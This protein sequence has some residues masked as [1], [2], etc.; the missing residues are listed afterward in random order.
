MPIDRVTADHPD[1]G[2]RRGRSKRDE[3]YREHNELTSAS[4][5]RW[6]PPRSAA[7]WPLEG[8]DRSARGGRT[9]STALLPPVDGTPR[10]CC[11]RS[12]GAAAELAF[13]FD[14]REVAGEV[15]RRL[16]ALRRP[17]DMRRRRHHRDRRQRAHGAGARRGDA[18]PARRRRTAPPPRDR[19]Q[20]PRRAAT[21][22]RASPDS[23]WLRVLVRR[24]RPG[25]RDEA[26][27]SATSVAAAAGATRHGAAAPSRPGVR[28]RARRTAARARSPNGS[29]RSPELVAQGLTNRQIAAPLEDQRAHRRH[30]RAAHPHQ[31]GFHQ[32]HPDRRLGYVPAIRSSADVRTQAPAA[33]SRH[34]HALGPP[35][36][37]RHLRHPA[38]RRGDR[39]RTRP[40]HPGR[41]RR[42]GPG[43][44]RRRRHHPARAG[45]RARPPRVRR[46]RRPGRRARRPRRR[47]GVRR[48]D[49]RRAVR[50][51]RRA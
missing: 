8:D 10:S 21:E 11:C 32:P 28:R 29:A 2:L 34:D 30:S 17:A 48:D 25:D 23:A 51:P 37:R 50:R 42:T 9:G 39:P 36:L 27:G 46:L 15:V 16:S 13:E 14:D 5:T 31:A 20:R 43:R 6:R 7:A 40:D 26:A 4:G 19:C 41:D 12:L 24:R 1:A 47:R 3:L 49:R 18:R 33:P 45:R 22:R 44:R 35:A 38:P